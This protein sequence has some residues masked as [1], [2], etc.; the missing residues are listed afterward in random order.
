MVVKDISV[1]NGSNSQTLCGTDDT[2][3]ASNV[4]AEC[5]NSIYTEYGKCKF[6]I[7]KDPNNPKGFLYKN[8]DGTTSKTGDIFSTITLSKLKTELAKYF[9]GADGK[10]TC[11]QSGGMPV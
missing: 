3:V 2:V 11:N 8:K 5:I 10:T 9:G 1:H 6:N 7:T 4:S